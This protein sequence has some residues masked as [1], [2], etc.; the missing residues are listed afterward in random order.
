MGSGFYVMRRISGTLLLPMVFH[1]LWDSSLFLNV[2]TGG[3]PSSVQ[4]AI[5]PLAIACAIAVVLKNRGGTFA[6]FRAIVVL[7]H[8]GFIFITILSNL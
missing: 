4:F 2:A 5:Y 3:T 7:P 6:R 1:G 8:L